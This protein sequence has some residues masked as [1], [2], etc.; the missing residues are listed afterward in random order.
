V[1]RR[2]SRHPPSCGGG[3]EEVKLLLGLPPPQLHPNFRSRSHWPKTNAIKKYRLEAFY[4]AK[5]AIGKGKPPRW[6]RAE[7]HV[8]FYF[9]VIRNRDEDN[10]SATMKSVWDGLQD[11]GIVENDSGLVHKTV[12]LLVDPAVPRVEIVV[13]ETS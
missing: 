5:L 1:D 4:A 3:G 11:A 8:T 7:T 12:T 13:E 9:K 10:I 2:G 6:K